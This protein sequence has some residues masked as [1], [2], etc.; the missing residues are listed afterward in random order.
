LLDHEQKKHKTLLK[1]AQTMTHA[2]S[3]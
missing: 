2:Y 1:W 3:F